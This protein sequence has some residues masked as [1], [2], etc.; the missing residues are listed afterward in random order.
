MSKIMVG[1]SLLDIAIQDT[2]NV[3]TV[4]DI[5]LANNLSITGDLQINQELIIPETKVEQQVVSYYQRRG[6]HPATN[7]NAD[8]IGGI[9]MWAIEVDFII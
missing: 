1:Q 7:L 5:A 4:F 8:S 3:E 6:I 9:G 2:G